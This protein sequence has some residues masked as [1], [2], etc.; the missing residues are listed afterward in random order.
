MIKH[1]ILAAAILTA[2]TS[3]ASAYGSST[4]EVDARQHRQME[5]IEEGRRNGSITRRE[6]EALMAEQRRIQ[7]IESQATRDGR[8]TYHER[9]V[10]RRAQN[11]ASRHIR[12][13]STDYE[14]RRRGWGWWRWGNGHRGH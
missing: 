13:E 12:E 7:A 14:R 4:R 2:A 5:R 3:A 10:L 6:Y 1:T 8:V 9:E 11:E